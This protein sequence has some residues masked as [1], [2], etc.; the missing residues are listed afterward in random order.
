LFWQH[1][2]SQCCSLD[3]FESLKSNVHLKRTMKLALPVA[4]LDH[5]VT[6]LSASIQAA[7]DGL[8][9]IQGLPNAP[10]EQI[11][12]VLSH[13]AS[14]ESGCHLGERLNRAYTNNLV[15]KDSF[16]AGNGGPSVDRKR[17]LDLSPERLAIIEQADPEIFAAA[18]N[19]TELAHVL[20]FWEQ[21]ANT[22]RKLLLA[23]ADATGSDDILKDAA[24]NYRMVDYD[25]HG[26]E[27]EAPRCGE[28]RDF[29]SFSLIHCRNPGLE[30][31]TAQGEW[32]SVAA[33]PTPDSA[34]LLFGWCTQ[35]R[36]NGRIPAALH[37]V[38]D[39]HEPDETV[40]PRRVTAVLFCAPKQPDTPLE[41]VVKEGEERRYIGGVKVG[42][43]RG[44]M[45]RKW[46]HREG[47]ED[48]VDRVYEEKEIRATNLKTQ[49]DV[50]NTFIAV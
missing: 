1:L 39:I 13:F 33:P 25:A 45:A 36:S 48:E 21:S 2:F 47:T 5:S 15:F 16:A 17:V 28:H 41:P 46:R 44:K 10:F 7:S 27:M 38:V 19:S 9:W 12:N 8:L 18:A 22:S 31:Q 37:R 14:G 30:V 32:L 43:L 23:L 40:V 29:G 6:E 24:F 26:D 34:L 50:V 4:S 11:A 42:Q 3:K 35:I 49:D 20:E